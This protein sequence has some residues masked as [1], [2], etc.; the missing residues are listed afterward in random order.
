MTRL[1]ETAPP[2]GVHLP[3]RLKRFPHPLDLRRVRVPVCQALLPIEIQ[4]GSFPADST[5]RRPFRRNA[6]RM[7]P[8][9]AAASR[10]FGRCRSP[11]DPL[12]RIR[13]QVQLAFRRR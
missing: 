6:V 5:E 1:A 4:A 2:S 3:G 13:F 7:S 8:L 10:A 12:C 11:C 9:P